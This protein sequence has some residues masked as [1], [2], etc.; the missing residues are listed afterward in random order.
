M[1]SVTASTSSPFTEPGFR[2]LAT[3][4]LSLCAPLADPAAPDTPSD[5]D[6]S[7]EL[8]PE[9]AHA[10]LAPAA[11]LVPVIARAELTVLLT[12]RTETLKRH[13]GQIAFPGGRMEPTDHDAV[14]T[15]L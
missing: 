13:S 3:T 11:V 12:Q 5:F 4:R 9:I 6:L 8:V 7:P 2:R 14:A 1:Q 10:P 15:A